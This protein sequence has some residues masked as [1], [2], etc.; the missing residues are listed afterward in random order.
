M[1]KPL[2][3][4]AHEHIFFI[5][6][7]I[8]MTRNV[9]AGLF[10][11]VFF[12]AAEAQQINAKWK[13]ELEASMKEFMVCKDTSINGVNPCS[14][15][16]GQ[17]VATVYKLDDFY[18]DKYDR[19]LTGSEMAKFIKSSDKWEQ[20]GVSLLKDVLEKAQDAA[21]KNIATV[22]V[23][24]DDKGIG[25]VAIVLPGE[26]SKSGTWG[27]DVPNSA[28]FF[29]NEKGESYIGKGLSYGFRNMK[30]NRIFVYQRKY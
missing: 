23:Y 16:S 5:N 19:Y 1:I 27:L 2:Y 17:S 7:Y 12:S 10:C 24:S 29:V 26:L 9:L 13:S 11:I 4:T 15:Y 25:H 21:N 8:M 20:L 28:S 22:A 6:C 30:R 14:K 3:L 18:S